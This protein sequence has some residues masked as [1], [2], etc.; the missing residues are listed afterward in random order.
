[1]EAG[2]NLHLP[3]SS[4]LADQTTG[5]PHP[6]GRSAV[7]LDR[8]GVLVRDVHFLR[9]IGGLEVLASVPEALCLLQG[10]FYLIVITN[11]SGVARGIF[12]EETLLSIHSELT[13]RL[14]AA[15]ALIDALYYCPHLAD[16][17]VKRY[18]AECDC[19][20][21]K[22]GMI[23]RAQQD[24]GIDPSRSYMVGDTPRDTQAGHAAG[25][26]CVQ[27]GEPT[28]QEPAQG[29]MFAPDLLAAARLILARGATPSLVN[30]TQLNQSGVN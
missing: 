10:R 28:T 18:A 5:S 15:E 17:P 26:S 2:L 21:P 24:W 16:A 19:R 14:L 22:P 8:D 4:R 9:E 6:E 12:T 20:K 7:F 27:L 25:T 30:Q 1:M 29:T 23:L 13:Q 3:A 11:Q